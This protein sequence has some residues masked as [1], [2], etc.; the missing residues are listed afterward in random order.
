LAA[1]LPKA[2]G[3]KAF[4]F[5]TSAIVDEKEVAADHAQLR[6]S[7]QSKRYSIAGEFSC[8]G[9]NTNSFLKL[10]GG[11]NKGLPNSD[12]LRHAQELAR[13]LLE[14]DPSGVQSGSESRGVP[15]PAP[16]LREALPSQKASRNSHKSSYV[17]LRQ[18]IVCSQISY[19]GFLILLSDAD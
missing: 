5:S 14:G 2:C 8:N 17:T 15:R 3:K 19:F 1:K 12:D 10:V 11:M 4:L 7:L 13:K 16:P 18:H 9:F 6:T